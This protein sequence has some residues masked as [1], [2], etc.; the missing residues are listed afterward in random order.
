MKDFLQ[1]TDITKTYVGFYIVFALL[2]VLA[3]SCELINYL[4]KINTVDFP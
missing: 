4:A 1:F 3:S 2:Y